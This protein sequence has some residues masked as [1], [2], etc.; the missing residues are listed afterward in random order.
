MFDR[1]GRAADLPGVP[2][3]SYRDVRVS[4]DGRR[5]AVST[6]DDV[7]TYDFA[8]STFSRLTTAPGP[9]R[10]PLWSRD[11]LRVLFTSTGTNAP[12]VM[13]RAA[14]GTGSDQL[15]FTRAKDALDTRAEA[16]SPDGKV[17]FTEVAPT[18]MCDIG[19]VD[20]TQPT[21]ARILV[22]DGSCPGYPAISPDGH[23]IAYM[24][25]VSGRSQV[26]VERYPEMGAR[27]Q[28]SIDGGTVPAWS[29]TGRELYFMDS[30]ARQVLAVTTDSGPTLAVG[31]P[32]VVFEGEFLPAQTGWRPYD[33]GPDGRFVII[34]SAS[35]GANAAA[36]PNIVLV[37]HWFEELKRLVASK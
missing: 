12:E 17:L 30:Y 21:D 32:K 36:A 22:H 27:Q 31:Q 4:P 2:T 8:R 15:V 1:Q 13:G 6:F 5:L 37:Q 10:S 16:W 26:Y 28:I 25:D 11:G 9:E 18:I 3:G 23:W 24:S 19:E 14:D 35:A 33:A 7:W 20:P 29:A 34:R